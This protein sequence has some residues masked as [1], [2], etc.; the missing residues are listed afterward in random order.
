MTNGERLELAM[1]GALVGCL[2]ISVALLPLF[3]LDW[4]V[5]AVVLTCVLPVAGFAIGWVFAEAFK[6]WEQRT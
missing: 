2:P 4:R 6:D 5:V 1:L 3:L